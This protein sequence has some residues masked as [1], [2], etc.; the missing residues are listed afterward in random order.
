MPGICVD[1]YVSGE[2]LLCGT[3]LGFPGGVMDIPGGCVRRAAIP[4]TG[5]LHPGWKAG[6]C[7][8]HL[9]DRKCGASDGTK[10]P[11]GCDAPGG[12]EAVNR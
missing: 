1:T 2:G 8:L 10:N 9:M 6:I 4:G 7:R 3:K 12:V 11:P 5:C